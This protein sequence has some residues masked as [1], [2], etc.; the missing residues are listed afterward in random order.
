MQE[1]G[2][3]KFD[4]DY[5][6]S[7]PDPSLDI[8]ALSSVRRDLWR[9]GLIGQAPDR[10]GGVGYGN[11]SCRV[12]PG[13]HRFLVSGS[14]TGALEWLQ[15]EHYAQVT[16]F[17]VDRNQVHATGPIQPSSEALTHGMIYELADAIQVILHVHSP[18]IW[19]A[20]NSLGLPM[21]SRHAAYGTAAMA[22][23]VAQLFHATDVISRG[24]FVMGG[25]LDGVI[26]MGETIPET[27]RIL[28]D[29]IERCGGT[30]AG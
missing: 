3:I 17:D 23:E 20:G 7:A 6:W 19:Q 16:G 27:G 18:L 11:V 1:E 8:T 2:V 10:Y 30:G 28:L 26:A 24:M 12:R 9:R 21:T 15:S 22:R 14:Q 13:E 5:R 25:H 4:L 29:C